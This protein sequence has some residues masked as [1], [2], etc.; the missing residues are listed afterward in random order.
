MSFQQSDAQQDPLLSV[1]DRDVDTLPASAANMDAN[2]TR[3]VTHRML[4]C[5]AC[6]RATLDP[7]ISVAVQDPRLNLCHI[8]KSIHCLYLSLLKRH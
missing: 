1:Q 2:A 8:Q 7:A 6:L 4:W 5:S 3:R